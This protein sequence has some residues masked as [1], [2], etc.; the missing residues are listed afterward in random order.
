MLE[1]WGT[2]LEEGEGRSRESRVW[3][4]GGQAREAIMKEV[5]WFS[6]WWDRI[7]EGGDRESKG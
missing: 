7:S 1:M 2:S 3:C 6:S 5:F 4:L